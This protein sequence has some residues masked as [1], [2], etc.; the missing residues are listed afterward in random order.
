MLLL[1]LLTLLVAQVPA[2]GL[3]PVAVVL[4][5]QRHGSDASA[6]RVATRVL[7]TCR[8]EGVAIPFELA[9]AVEELKAAGVTDPR[10]CNGTTA[11]LA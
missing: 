1:P 9:G 5:S 8:R 4:T 3:A 6:T 10:N 2:T 7:E 11:C